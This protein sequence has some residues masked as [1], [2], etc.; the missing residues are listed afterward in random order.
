VII[1]RMNDLPGYEIEKV[2]GEVFGLTVRSRN[3]GSQVGASLN[4]HRVP[5]RH[6]RAGLD[7]DRD[8]RVRNGGEGEQAL[9]TAQR[10]VRSA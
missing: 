5:L 3:V 10:I 7:L 2:C 4:D 1:S 9:A 6:L 8:L